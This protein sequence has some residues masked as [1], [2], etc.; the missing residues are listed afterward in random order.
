MKITVIGAGNSGLAM[1]GH[2]SKEGNQVTLWN[3]SR[4]A[5]AKLIESRTIYCEGAIE[6][7]IKIHLVTDNIKRAMED[8]DLILITTP[9]N[10]HKQLAKLIAQNIKK[11]TLIILNPGR[12]FGALEFEYVYRKWNQEIEPII[13]ETQTIIYT[14]RKTAEDSVNIISLKSDVL[15]ST[16]NADENEGIIASLPESIRGYF[17][18]ARSMIETSIG[19]V[20]MILHCAPILLN[21]GWTESENNMYKYYYDGITP[22]IGRFIEK[23][24]QE[25]IMVSKKLGLEVESTKEWLE[26]T[27]HVEGESLYDCIQNNKAYETIDAPSSMEHRYIYEDIPCGLV[28]LEAAG[29]RLGLQMKNT[30]LII[31]LASSMLE[32]D[33]RQIGRNLNYLCKYSSNNEFKVLFNRR[34]G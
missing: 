2:L 8:P 5:I 9:A 24:D 12:T 10:A 17:I 22:S 33:F 34:S 25:R 4:P 20:G 16:L 1:A 11:E 32:T 28:P 21:T 18:P 29:R 14:C 6:G 19:N 27:Y 13:A 7:E 26:R 23:I 30:G 31:E 3:R 15:L